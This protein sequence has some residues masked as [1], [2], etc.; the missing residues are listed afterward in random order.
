M[1]Y[2]DF[3]HSHPPMGI[4]INAAIFKLMGFNFIAL[5]LVP[6]VS[7]AL[8]G[9]LLYGLSRTHMAGGPA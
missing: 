2:R 6:V 3:F 4:L 5:K 7:I 9:L 1:P 8:A